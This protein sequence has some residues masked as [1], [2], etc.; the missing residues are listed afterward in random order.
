MSGKIDLNIV[1]SSYS[2]HSVDSAILTLRKIITCIS[3][4]DVIPLDWKD[5][6]VRCFLTDLKEVSIIV[7]NG[8]QTNEVRSY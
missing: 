5:Q 6:A 2:L 7:I 8:I 4:S 1:R 3:G